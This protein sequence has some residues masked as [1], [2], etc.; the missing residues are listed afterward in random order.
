GGDRG[1]A[2]PRTNLGPRPGGPPPQHRDQPPQGR[3]PQ[4]RSGGAD[5]RGFVRRP[6]TWV[7][8]EGDN[9]SQGLNPADRADHEDRQELRDWRRF[10]G[11]GDGQP[12]E[13][14]PDGRPGGA[15]HR[16]RGGPPDI[17][18]GGQGHLDGGRD[19][20]D[21]E[22]RPDRPRDDHGRPEWRPDAFP[23]AYHS[24]ARFH[25]RAYRPPPRFLGHRWGYGEILPPVWFGPD[26]LIADWWDYD[27][28]A[29][30]PGYDWVRVGDDAVLVDEYTGRIV[31]VV[32]GLFW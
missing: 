1:G 18:G 25:V 31:Q 3:P 4:D 21:G 13:R 20:R 11:G 24:H 23:H 32:R 27:L 8:T 12:G 28:P 16:G 19:H 10:N 9:T 30:P 2:D 29:P 7:D 15:D 26:Y 5:G 14:R 22:H 6:G 17:R